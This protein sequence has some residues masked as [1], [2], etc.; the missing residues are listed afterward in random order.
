MIIFTHPACLA[1][2]PGPQHPERP[3]RLEVV[4]EGLRAEHGDLDWREAP[5]AK[6]GDLRRVHTEGLWMSREGQRMRRVNPAVEVRHRELC[7]ING[8]T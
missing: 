2:D 5:L 1:H 8:G 7:A 4:L 6:L 3:A